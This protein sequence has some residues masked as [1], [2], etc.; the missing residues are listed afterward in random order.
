VFGAR[1]REPR[2]RRAPDSRDAPP[3]WRA[4]SRRLAR[5]LPGSEFRWLDG[6]GHFIQFARSQAVVDAIRR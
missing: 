5:E 3:S 1:R 4:R 2:R 6:C